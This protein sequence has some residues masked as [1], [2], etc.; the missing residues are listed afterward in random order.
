MGL[1]PEQTE[2]P[3]EG[4]LRRREASR[5]VLTRHGLERSA[6]P[7]FHRLL[8]RL[9]I[10]VRPPHFEEF[11]VNVAL[12][13]GLM[14]VLWS[15]ASFIMNSVEVPLLVE[16]KAGLIFA[17]FMG[18]SFAAIFTIQSRKLGLPRWEDL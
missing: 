10:P 8:W 4:E 15:A 7:I 6:S 14:A 2:N 1:E 3:G 5:A 16:A 13:G 9:G 11:S 12:F 18:L 17:T